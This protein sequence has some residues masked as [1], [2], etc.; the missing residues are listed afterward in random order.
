MDVHATLF[1]R[2]QSGNVGFAP[3]SSMFWF[4]EASQDRHGDY[5]PEVHDSDGLLVAPDAETRLWRPLTNPA[6]LQRTD[7]QLPAFAGFGLMQRDRELRDYEDL[8]ALYNLRPSLWVE[9]VGL[10][11]AGHVR[12]VEIPSN[13]EFGDN[14]VAF[15]SPTE[16]FPARTPIDLRWRLN[17]TV[18]PSFGGPP[19]W[20]RSTRQDVTGANDGRTRYIVDFDG[21][22]MRGL[23][24]GADVTAEISALPPAALVEH[25]VIRNEHDGSWRISMSFSA[26]PGSPACDLTARLVTDGHPVTETWVVR[27]KP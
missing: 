4:G 24:P 13:S 9:P 26:P 19:G 20:V 8:E 16:P 11:P 18:A 25:Q 12:L 5:R 14:I 1:F 23:E 10:W 7:F 3:M 15:W 17:W 27:W 6:D 21:G 2:E 22:S